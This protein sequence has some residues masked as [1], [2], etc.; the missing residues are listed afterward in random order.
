MEIGELRRI[1]FYLVGLPL[2]AVRLLWSA[3]FAL[4]LVTALILIARVYFLFAFSAV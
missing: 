3:S 1:A 4:F 2:G